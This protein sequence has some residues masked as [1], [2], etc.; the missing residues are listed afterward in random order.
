MIMPSRFEGLVLI[1]IESLLSKVPVIAAFAKGLS[2][3]LPLDWSLQFQ[4][5]N[6]QELMS[7]F[8]NIKNN[9]YDLTQLKN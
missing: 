2:E 5:E 3:T 8:D 7:V 6:E 9:K 4:L 1:P